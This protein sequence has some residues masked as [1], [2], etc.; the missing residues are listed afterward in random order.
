MLI[1]IFDTETTGLPQTRFIQPGKLDL[2]PHIVQLSYVLLDVEK[3][4]IVREEDFII[5]LPIGVVVPEES[6]KI[7]GITDAISKE[8]GIFMEEALGKFIK[9]F[10]LV[11]EIVGHNIDFDV[12]MILVETMRSIQSM[13]GLLWPTI[14]PEKYNTIK[15]FQDFIDS[16]KKAKQFCTMKNSIDLCC[17]KK[18]NH[19][20]KEYNKFPRL[21]ELHQHLFGTIPPDLHNSLVDV[22]ACMHCYWK[23]K[24]NEDKQFTSLLL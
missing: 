16:F 7:H 12:N 3:K 15:Q 17:I 21:E 1:M 9:D 8:K 6:S 18:T 22:Y 10:A 11:S 2:W 24:F 5:K 14:N 4:T 13:N 19:N 20:G 23:M